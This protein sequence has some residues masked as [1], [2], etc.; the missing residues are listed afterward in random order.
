MY[1]GIVT[2]WWR[3]GRP[4]LGGSGSLDLCLGCRSRA[5]H[6][7]RQRWD[8]RRRRGRVLGWCGAWL[9][10]LLLLCDNG[11]FLGKYIAEDGQK[12]EYC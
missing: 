10:L 7:R 2:F 6:I 5:S 1:G 12:V 9:L 8:G 3:R 4:L 11:R